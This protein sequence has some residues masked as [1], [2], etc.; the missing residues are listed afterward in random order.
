MPKT[1]AQRNPSM[2]KP[3]T[4]ALASI[5]RSAFMTKAN[6]PKVTMV[7]G[8][9][10]RRSIGRRITLIMPKIMA[11]TNAEAKPETWTPG[12]RYAVT[13]MANAETKKWMIVFIM[14]LL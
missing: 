12:R 2:V 3:G 4:M 1:N 9:V 8:R 7:S 6:N 5:T 13:N 14:I 10:R 11:N